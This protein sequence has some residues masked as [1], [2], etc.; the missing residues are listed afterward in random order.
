[1]DRVKEKIASS[2]VHVGIKIALAGY[3]LCSS[4]CASAEFWIASKVL[5][6]TKNNAILET[7]QVSFRPHNHYDC[8]TKEAANS[9]S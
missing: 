2:D 6:V 7:I 3:K 1:M 4:L 8:Y 9:P 5:S